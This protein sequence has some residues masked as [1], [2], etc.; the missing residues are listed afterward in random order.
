MQLFRTFVGASLGLFMAAAAQAAPASSAL[1][2][3]VRETEDADS[4]VVERWKLYGASKA[5]VI[6]ID[7]YQNG[8]PRLSMA[9]KDAEEVATAL[10]ARGFEV[11]LLKNLGGDALR[12]ELRKFYALQGGDPEAR[13]F[14]WF[15]GHGH[16]EDGEGYIVP[17]DAPP[18][19]SA[20]FRFSALHMGD[21][22][23]LQRIAQA[24]H[25]FSI[26]DSC[27]AGT[28]FSQQRSAPPAA[29]THASTKPVRQFL[30]SGDADQTV[31]DDG[32]F[33]KLFLAALDGDEAAD[34]NGDGYVTATEIGFHITNRLTNFTQGAQTPR[35]GKL[36][37]LKYDRGDFV[38]LLPQQQS[39]AHLASIPVPATAPN[40][41]NP[42]GASPVTPAAVELAFWNSIKE[43]ENTGDFEAYLGTY[44][45]GQFMLLARAR[46]DALSRQEE[47]AAE[48]ARRAA[49]SS[50][51][52]QEI[53]VE[54]EFWN[55]IKNSAR[56]ED[57]QSYL[58]A[59]PNGRY[60]A[61][62]RSRADSLVA[63]RN[64]EQLARERNNAQQQQAAAEASER[65]TA[66][67]VA[68]ERAAQKLAVEQTF[69]KSI[70]NSTRPEDYR[71]YLST[72]PD[73]AYAALARSRAETRDARPEPPQ[74][75]RL[76]APNVSVPTPGEP[77]LST[78]NADDVSG[79]LAYID[80][81]EREIRKALEK[82]IEQTRKRTIFDSTKAGCDLDIE[83]FRVL[84]RRHDGI[85]LE[86]TSSQPFVSGV[87]NYGCS[88]GPRK[89]ENFLFEWTGQTAT[90]LAMLVE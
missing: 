48:A 58:S 44:P 66:E 85:V 79:I 53:A 5:L 84:G 43:S 14:V 18:P 50:R 13:L 46:I 87:G 45:E 30:T 16:T 75:A 88:N 31:S 51:A 78:A 32:T 20:E 70:E 62:A 82:L 10:E 6:G 24:K 47:E 90:P 8:W 74:I 11:T 63:R 17:A 25:V 72:Y 40:P 41:A 2:V 29:I 81:N 69:W 80:D 33:R 86:L 3:D 12:R 77:E 38:F 59:Y 55:S 73:G 36:R 39:S 27:F 28:V 52:A 68:A 23:S 64:A 34:V 61:L 49:A 15:A 67:R 57:H 35:S 19:G 21:L 60:A 56:P 37:D 76:S 7:D 4:K 26:F 1:Y 42:H 22:A 65:A 54:Q 71:S 89:V 9:V 83:A